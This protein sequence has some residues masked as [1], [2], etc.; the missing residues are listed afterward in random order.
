MVFAYC[1]YVFFLSKF[2]CFVCLIVS[3]I[4]YLSIFKID[5]QSWN[6]NLTWLLH[7]YLVTSY[8]Y[9]NKLSNMLSIFRSRTTRRSTF[10]IKCSRTIGQ[11]RE[12]CWRCFEYNQPIYISWRRRSHFAQT[13]WSFFTFKC[14]Q[15]FIICLYHYTGYIL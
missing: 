7:T 3:S 14:C 15:S 10:T 4:T 1:A 9:Q 12:K 8:L 11:R 13:L 5:L 2:K 6:W